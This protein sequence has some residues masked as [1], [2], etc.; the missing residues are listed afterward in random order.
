LRNL[1]ADVRE[2]PATAEVSRNIVDDEP[3]E[4]DQWLG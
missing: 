1:E 3:I 2:G 4:V